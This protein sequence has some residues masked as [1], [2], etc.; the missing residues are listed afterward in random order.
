MW[1]SS[2]L[3]PTLLSSE[4]HRS[5]R[6]KNNPTTQRRIP[7]H[8]KKR[9]TETKFWAA[10]VLAGNAIALNLLFILCC[11][12]VVTIGPSLC[13]LYSGVRFMIK[14]EGWFRGFWEGFRTHWIRSGILGIIAVVCQAKVLYDL[15]SAVLF[16]QDMGIG[17]ELIITHSIIAFLPALLVASL[18]PLNIYIPG[19]TASWLRN[20]VNL[21]FKAPAAAFL[22]ACL[23]LAPVVLALFFTV[24]A[25]YLLIIIVA[26]WF[27]LSAFV[28]TLFYKDALVELLNEYREEHPDEDEEL[29]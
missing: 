22:A 9:I 8:K 17:M 26:G 4:R 5:Q 1:Q 7:V 19:D 16:H 21:V 18:W 13:G 11:L 6:M 23:F 12:P 10:L 24:I 25:W 29:E 14:R 20:T 27:V 3:I 2:I 28:A 15:N